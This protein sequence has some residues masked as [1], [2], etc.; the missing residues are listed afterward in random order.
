VPNYVDYRA[1]NSVFSS[2]RLNVNVNHSVAEASLCFMDN[3]FVNVMPRRTPYGVN[4]AGTI[5][6]YPDF[7]KRLRQC[8]DRRRQFLDYFTRG[9]LV[10]ECLLAEDCPD[11]HV[12]AYVR[13]GKA[14]LLLLNQSGRGGVPFHCDLAPWL[15]SSSG[16]YQINCYDMDGRLLTTADAAGDWRGVT[17]ELDKNDIAVYEITAR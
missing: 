5:A 16:R 9:T 13:S 3:L 10:G 8:A 2:P 6:Q 14:L 1:F 17:P 12:T 15:Q 11:A 7:D 4:G